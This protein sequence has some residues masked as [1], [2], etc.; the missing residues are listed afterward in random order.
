M[1]DC[2]IFIAG[3]QSTN[4]QATNSIGHYPEGKDKD[5]TKPPGCA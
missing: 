3:S 4:R 1:M 2:R 5:L